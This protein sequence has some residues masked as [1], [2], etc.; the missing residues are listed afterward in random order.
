[1]QPITTPLRIICD[2]I[3]HGLAE[4]SVTPLTYRFNGVLNP[5]SEID[6]QLLALTSGGDPVRCWFFIH[7]AVI[8]GLRDIARLDNGE[9]LDFSTFAASGP[10]HS[11][12]GLPAH[13]L[14]QAMAKCDW[15]GPMKP[16]LESFEIIAREEMA[17]ADPRCIALSRMGYVPAQVE[18][19]RH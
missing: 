5:V 2:A 12:R 18:I 13:G 11:D 10:L 17:K 15:I 8:G 7:I 14:L 6:L 3:V 19:T 9:S 1:M 4:P 16:Y